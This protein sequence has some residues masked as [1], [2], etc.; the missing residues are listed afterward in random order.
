MYFFALL[1]FPK[2]SRVIFN[3][4][5]IKTRY[6]KLIFSYTV[7]GLLT[8]CQLWMINSFNY[9]NCCFKMVS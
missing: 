3:K 4:N 6:Y 7:L 8:V 5:L 1:D 2:N 9:S